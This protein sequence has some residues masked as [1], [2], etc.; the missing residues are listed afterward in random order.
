VKISR[1]DS[2]GNISSQK[3][4]ISTKPLRFSA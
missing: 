3:E 4:H 1:A 2:D